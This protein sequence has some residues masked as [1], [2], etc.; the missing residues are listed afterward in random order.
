MSDAPLFDHAAK[1]PHTAGAKARDTSF[2]AAQA[3]SGRAVRLRDKVLS[4]LRGKSMTADECAEAIGETIITTRPRLSELAARSTIKD[5]GE[6]RKNI[7]GKQAI[8][9]AVT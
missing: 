4:A 7:S 9:W 3:I 2:D 8:V 6:R 5:T 1:Y